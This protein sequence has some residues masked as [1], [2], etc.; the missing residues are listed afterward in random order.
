MQQVPRSVS[1]CLS[2]ESQK[3][4]KVEAPPEIAQATSAKEATVGATDR[5]QDRLVHRAPAIRD[6]PGFQVSNNLESSDS[7]FN[8]GGELGAKS[9]RAV[10][11]SLINTR[12]RSR[13]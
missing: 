6:N 13:P 4:Q 10:A 2:R 11:H 9:H 7:G 3:N 1:R 8:I 5:D 12:I